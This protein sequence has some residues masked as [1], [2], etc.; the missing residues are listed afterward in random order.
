M[1]NVA[2]NFFATER[3]VQEVA[4]IAKGKQHRGIPSSG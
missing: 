2:Y 3:A 4:R 1:Q